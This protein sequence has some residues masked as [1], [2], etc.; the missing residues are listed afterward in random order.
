MR[1]GDEELADCGGSC[2]RQCAPGCTQTAASNYNPA[3][4]D[5]DGSC[6]FAFTPC[7][8]TAAS[9]YDPRADTDYFNPALGQA[10]NYTCAGIVRAL[11]PVVGDHLGAVDHHRGVGDALD[12]SPHGPVQVMEEP[13]YDLVQV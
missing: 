1:N 8:D 5:D 2:P 10:C 13:E 6:T 9:N 7:A 3:A 12:E 11:V 4:Q